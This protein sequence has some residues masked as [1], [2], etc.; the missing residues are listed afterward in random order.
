MSYSE[1]LSVLEGQ[2]WVKRAAIFLL[3]LD[4]ALDNLSSAPA[5]YTKCSEAIELCWS[6]LTDR[7]LSPEQLAYYLDSDEMQN[8]PL[9]EHHFITESLEQDSLILILLVIGFFAHQAYK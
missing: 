1:S 5:T 4:Q 6:W 3:I 8:G 2:M 9:G 7:S